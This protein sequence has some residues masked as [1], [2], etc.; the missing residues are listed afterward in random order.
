MSTIDAVLEDIQN[1]EVANQVTYNPP[2]DL[3]WEKTISVD[4]TAANKVLVS[5]DS[6][7]TLYAVAFW[8]TALGCFMNLLWG[9]YPVDGIFAGIVMVCYANAGMMFT[10]ICTSFASTFHQKYL[11]FFWWGYPAI[12]SVVGGLVLSINVGTLMLRPVLVIN[13]L[14]TV[15][16]IAT[17][18]SVGVALNAMVVVVSACFLGD[19]SGDN[20]S[21]APHTSPLLCL[22]STDDESQKIRIVF[23]VAFA[24]SGAASLNCLFQRCSRIIR[25]WCHMA[26]GLLNLTSGFLFAFQAGWIGITFG[27]AVAPLGYSWAWSY[28]VL[29]VNAFMQCVACIFVVVGLPT[30]PRAKEERLMQHREMGGITTRC[31]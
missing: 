9:C 28:V 10:L 19:S 24:S 7:G 3:N 5:A 1:A 27:S 25:Y 16:R 26:G 11:S 14:P 2:S 17:G 4:L 31:C 29:C 15:K 13:S 8:N 22:L 18:I 20:P 30:G 21:V 6:L 23:Y 12:V